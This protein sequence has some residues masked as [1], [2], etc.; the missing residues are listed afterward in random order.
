MNRFLFQTIFL[1]F[2]KRE[3]HDFG[4]TFPND[5]FGSTFPNDCFGSTFPKGG[6]GGFEPF[7]QEGTDD[8]SPE[9][10]ELRSDKLLQFYF[11]EYLY[12]KAGITGDYWG[13][14]FGKQILKTMETRDPNTDFIFD[15]YYDFYFNHNYDFQFDE[16]IV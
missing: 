3:K 11:K 4:S 8:D 9:L 2:Y 14:P 12:Y 7:L 15:I 5:C 10:I 16:I 6:K 13:C 1:R